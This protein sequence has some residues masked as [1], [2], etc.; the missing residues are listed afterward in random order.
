MRA[1][2]FLTVELLLRNMK[3]AAVSIEMPSESAEDFAEL[4]YEGPVRVLSAQECQHFLKAIADP[5]HPSPLDW[6]KGQ[7]AN[8][9]IF[10]EIGSHPAIVDRVSAILG[11]DVMLWGASM[12]DRAPGAV[13]PWHSDIESSLLPNKTV[14]VWLGLENTN[15]K[16][17]L[18]IIP[19]SHH[20]GVTLQQV[21]HEHG[22]ARDEATDN[23][24]L[25]WARA[26]DERSHLVKLDMADGDA[27]FLDGQLWHG[28]RNLFSET[29]R[30]L[31]LQYATPDAAIRI[32]DLNY[33][34][35]PFRQFSFPKPACVMVK[36]SGTTDINRIVPPPVAGNNAAAAPRLTSRVCPVHLPLA[37]PASA[38]WKP[39]FLF[40][41]S[42]SEL[43]LLSCHVSVL[44]P[45]HCPHP[46]HKHDDEEL[47]ILLRGEVLITLPE[48]DGGNV[49]HQRR[50]TAGQFV[51]YPV[52]FP[53][54]LQTVSEEPANYLMFKWQNQSRTSGDH[55]AFGQ[56]NIFETVNGS[57]ETGFSTQAMFE[58]STPYLSK[59]H[60]HTSS[61]TPSAGYEPHIDSHDVAIVVLEGEVEL[62]GQ[63]VGPHGVV[64]CPAGE[65]HGIH[66]P[67]DVVAKYIVFEFHG[68]QMA[69]ADEV[70]VPPAAPLP[71][72]PRS[73]RTLMDL[74]KGFL[75]KQ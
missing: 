65:P 11:P 44:M 73:K 53:H 55:L 35:W 75:K 20:F 54:T 38:G 24:I 47:L 25:N 51:Y 74:L 41:G 26:R 30:A 29:R 28:S 37:P 12:Q 56:F 36:G 69:L 18:R 58:G 62:L 70:A 49:D 3:S 22:K 63:R 61:L 6:N 19:H 59:L 4:G 31:L 27:V 21:R 7:A 46:P 8:S 60:C 67:G 57:V 71:D 48:A 34:D 68:N 13:H 33:L 15:R 64:F 39:Y 2:P 17:S 43:S 16:S 9:R 32:P 50:L 10:Y 52:D 72:L 42:T 40:H 23:D 1:T 14:S 5:N 45:G 66:N